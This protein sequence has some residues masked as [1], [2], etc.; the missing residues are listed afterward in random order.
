MQWLLMNEPNHSIYVRSDQ[1]DENLVNGT[2]Q[3][4]FLGKTSY[5]FILC[6]VFYTL[7]S[8]RNLLFNLEMCVMVE[9]AEASC[10][11]PLGMLAHSGDACSSDAEHLCVASLVQLQR[12]SW[13]S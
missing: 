2:K 8:A 11:F 7:L 3:L 6:Q 5:I 1:V 9:Q 13:T 4:I 10:F 12:S